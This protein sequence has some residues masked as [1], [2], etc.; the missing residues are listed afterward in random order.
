[1][2]LAL[3]LA[4]LLVP[5]AAALD[6]LPTHVTLGESE[7]RFLLRLP[8]GGVLR[9]E[10]TGGAVVAVG[11]PG[12]LPGAFAQTPASF[13]V[14]ARRPEESWHGLTGTFD[15]VAR[16]PDPAQD[17]RVSVRDGSG[18]GTEFEWPAVER[19][20]PAGAW[21]AVALVVAAWALRRR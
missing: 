12:G 17:V 14:D 1:M 10:A 18:A 2:R 19:S 13:A 15:L 21:A 6:A 4:T 5:T 9:V 8:R 16:R 3:L 7:A 11:E 20:V